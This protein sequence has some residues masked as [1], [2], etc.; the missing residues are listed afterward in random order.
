MYAS[1]A[2]P[3]RQ[4]EAMGIMMLIRSGFAFGC[5]FF[6]N[7][8]LKRS[9]A[10]VFLSVLGGIAGVISIAALPLYFWGRHSRQWC[11][12]HRLL[13]LAVP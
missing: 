13:K 11:A 8:W 2:F 3:G 1:A 7:N 4:S 5:M 12:R 6:I 9:G 10:L